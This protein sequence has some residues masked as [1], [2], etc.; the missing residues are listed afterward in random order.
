MA[1]LADVHFLAFYVCLDYPAA[2]VGLY[3]SPNA[4]ALRLTLCSNST[5]KHNRSL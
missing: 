3:K 4:K 1:Y 2:P 5:T